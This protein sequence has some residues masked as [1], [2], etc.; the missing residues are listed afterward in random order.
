MTRLDWDKARRHELA[1]AKAP[2]FRPKRS[3]VAP[4]DKQ[5]SYVAHLARRLGCD[6]PVVVS[7]AQAS[8][9]I[10]VLKRRIAT[11]ERVDSTRGSR[12]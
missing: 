9:A 11:V 3:A 12:A 10:R 5:R 2:V 8:Q 6:P 7:R 4:T 1:Q